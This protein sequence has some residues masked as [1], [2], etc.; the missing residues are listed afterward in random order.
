MSQKLHASPETPSSDE[1]ETKS[2]SACQ[3][4]IS[5]KASI[6]PQCR[7]KIKGGFNIKG[8]LV[9]LGMI[10]F[11]IVAIAGCASTPSSSSTSSSSSYS[12][13]SS[14]NSTMA[15]VQAK[16]FVKLVLKSPSSADFPF[17][18]EGVK[19]STDTYEVNSY[20]DSQNGFGAMIRSTYSITL[21]YTGGDS[22]DQRNWQVLEFTMDGEDLLNQ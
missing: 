6:C 20:V 18:G 17:F 21:K 8:C 16:N 14:D 15:Y 1:V 13:T 3:S 19:V 22:A 12:S 10:L 11:L 2:C 9:F 4:I 7:T 5:K